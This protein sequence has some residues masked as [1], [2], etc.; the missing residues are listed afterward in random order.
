MPLGICGLHE[1]HMP[2]LVPEPPNGNGSV[3]AGT[4]GTVARYASEWSVNGFSGGSPFP[5][6]VC[7]VIS[8][9]VPAFCGL[10]RHRW[11]RIQLVVDTPVARHTD[12]MLRIVF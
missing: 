10:T 6:Q 9:K 8:L 11:R 5:A 4:E 2:V 3:V 12:T 7:S 1:I